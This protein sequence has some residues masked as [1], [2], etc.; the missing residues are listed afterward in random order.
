[1]AQPAF[2]LKVNKNYVIENFEN[3]L[4][5]LRDYHYDPAVP[6][7]N[8]DFDDT[9]RSLYE[10][11]ADLEQS[12]NS[13][14]LYEEPELGMESVKA[15]RILG[16]CL[17]VR[18]KRGEEAHTTLLAVIRLLL[19]VHSQITVDSI[20]KFIDLTLGCIER[21]QILKF[22]FNFNTLRLGD[23][24]LGTFTHLL[25]NTH[26]GEVEGEKVYEYEGQGAVTL[27]GS[28]MS[29]AP[30]NLADMRKLKLKKIL[31]YGHSFGIFDK[32]LQKVEDAR[33]L[34]DYYQD[35]QSALDRVTPA[36]EKKL[37]RYS[38]GDRLMVR[39][40]ERSGVKSVCHTIDPEYERVEG[41]L[42]VENEIYRTPRTY[43]LQNLHPG[44]LLWVEFVANE[45]FPFKVDPVTIN[46]FV[47]EYTEHYLGDT[48]PCVFIEDFNKGRGTRWLSDVGLFVNVTGDVSEDA[49]DAMNGD[50][51]TGIRLEESFVDGYGATGVNGEFRNEG[52]PDIDDDFD[53]EKFIDDARNNFFE[54]FVDWQQPEDEIA[55]DRKRESNGTISRDEVILT[56]RLLQAKADKSTSL[57]TVDRLTLLTMSL[58]LLRIAND[59][60][61]VQF[62]RHQ[63][64]YMRQI[65][66]FA[67]GASPMTLSLRSPEEMEQ[68]EDVRARNK[69]VGSLWRYKEPEITHVTDNRELGLKQSARTD[70]PEL[71]DQLVNAS[72]ILY[73]K[74][75][76]SEINRIKKSIAAKLGVDDV[77]RDINGDLPYF[78]VESE[79]LEFK[80]SCAQP[81]YNNRTNCVENDIE[82]QKWNILKAVCAFLNSQRGGE[83]LVGVSDNGYA[84][85][86]A[87][88]IE[89]LHYKHI[90]SEKTSDRLR[91]YIKNEIDKA[92]V[93][94]DGNAKGTDITLG[95]VHCEVDRPKD[96]IEVLRIK[97]EPYRWDVV[98]IGHEKRPEG[99]KNAYCR[100]SGA[101]TP[102][103]KEGIRQLKMEKMAVLDRDNLKLARLYESMDN[104]RIVV[105]RNYASR[106]GKRDRMVEPF[107][108]QPEKNRVIAYDRQAK[109]M[110]IFKLSRFDVCEVKQEKWKNESHH[111]EVE[112]D[113]FGIMLQ[114]GMEREHVVVKMTEYALCLLK[115]EF[116][117]S[118]E[119]GV[120][121]NTNDDADR[122]TYAWKV[123]MDICGPSGLARFAMGLPLE[124]KIESGDGVTAYI[125]GMKDE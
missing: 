112:A 1:M 97:I 90:I 88:D 95:C 46:E 64:D 125:R 2:W 86:L 79:T 82:V 89:L 105:L 111:R 17:L 23:F 37:K 32:D 69:I 53:I 114:P 84:V 70:K 65:V 20:D 38:A 121:V 55:D 40:D 93:S 51:P 117:Y 72:N 47:G 34:L 75:D 124:V 41:K 103:S 113:I 85:G 80:A 98:K 31:E 24:M 45:Q 63:L 81:P 39:I 14:A 66:L 58:A 87:Q 71:V 107:R 29:I 101:S 102:L 28:L 62:L 68:V 7:E 119:D 16:S 50:Y 60:E 27:C 116:A 77:Y 94:N 54:A 115:E 30:F 59:E 110:R 49:V 123:E 67:Q 106:S 10:V 15:L 33:G 99:F 18:R 76:T 61:D 91:T 108:I 120:S 52:I 13:C 19:L 35:L 5:Y 9:C 78:G 74:I 118:P 57:G 12:I 8:R 3:L 92:F 43:L 96:N 21:R 6:D 26:L 56:G 4:P 122:R 104:K 11:C 25:A 42:S 73:D 36:S 109:A 44:D 83:L 48:L 100:T 22:D